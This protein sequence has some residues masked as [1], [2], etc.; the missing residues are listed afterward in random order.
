[1]PWNRHVHSPGIGTC[2]RMAAQTFTSTGVPGRCFVSEEAAF[3]LSCCQPIYPPLPLPHNAASP[4]D[5]QAGL[6]QTAGTGN[7]H[8]RQLNSRSIRLSFSWECSPW[9]TEEWGS[10]RQRQR[11]K[12]RGTGEKEESRR[13]KMETQQAER[14]MHNAVWNHSCR[15]GGVQRKRD[16]AGIGSMRKTALGRRER[17]E[18]VHLREGRKDREKWDWKGWDDEYSNSRDWPQLPTW[19]CKNVS[20]MNLEPSPINAYF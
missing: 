10:R 12:L 8:I 19:I 15:G 13:A 1:M 5:F 14:A 17:K 3:W 9:E 6:F 16:M 7:E 18:R 20:F 11:E 4:R 2:P